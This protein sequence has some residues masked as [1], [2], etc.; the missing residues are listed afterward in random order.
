MVLGAF[1]ILLFMW[2]LI[3][4]PG[5]ILADQTSAIDE[6]RQSLT[7]LTPPEFLSNADKSRI[8]NLLIM[9]GVAAREALEPS[10]VNAAKAVD[11][12]EGLDSQ[13]GQIRH[14]EKLYGL[15]NHFFLLSTGL[16]GSK[17]PDTFTF[18]DESK[19]MAHVLPT[20]KDDKGFKTGLRESY[21]R[22]RSEALRIMQQ[23]PDKSGFPNE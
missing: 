5:R 19:T 9:C 4:A 17:N 15:A 7:G 2:N 8:E 22:M 6:V 13:I 3:S 14:H 18:T 21:D 16:I 12:I 10:E 20:L 11:A 23:G 1:T